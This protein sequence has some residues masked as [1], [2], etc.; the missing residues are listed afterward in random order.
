VKAIRDDRDSALGRQF[1]VESLRL[2]PNNDAAW[3]WLSQTISD[4]RKKLDCLNRALAINPGNT[5]A[6]TAK[7]QLDSGLSSAGASSRMTSTA[8][9]SAPAQTPSAAPRATGM[10]KLL[11]SGNLNKGELFQKMIVSVACIGIAVAMFL[12]SRAAPRGDSLGPLLA[13]GTVI[14]LIALL[15]FMYSILTTIG[16]QITVY[17]NGISRTRGSKIDAWHWEDFTAMRIAEKT[18]TYRKYGAPI[19][20][21]HTY[22]CRLLIDNK[23]VLKIDKDIQKYREIGER[24]TQK[25]TPIFFDRDFKAYRGGETAHYGNIQLNREGIRQGWRSIRW[26]DIASW[27]LN[28]GYLIIQR[29][30]RGKF[31]LQLLDVPNAYVFMSMLEKIAAKGH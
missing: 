21:M 2:D 4:S 28:Q 3:V 17:D 19:Y 22:T 11:E 15:V 10:G 9:V 25:T 1:L 18:I 23:M 29:R 20:Q 14:P 8:S 31:R 26:D 24:I 6:L 13:V 16:I 12:G 27:E 30:G 7:R 5:Q